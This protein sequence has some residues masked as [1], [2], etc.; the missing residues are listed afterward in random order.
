MHS[1][2]GVRSASKVTPVYHHHAGTKNTGWG[3]DSQ[4]SALRQVGRW[5]SKRLS[6]LL[7]LQTA[8]P[9]LSKLA[10][11]MAGIPAFLRQLTNMLMI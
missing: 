10:I 11:S 7:K 5:A 8:L 6:S 2:Q 1:D 4:V 3:V 9:Y